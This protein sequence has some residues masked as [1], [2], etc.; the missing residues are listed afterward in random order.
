[1]AFMRG[2]PLVTKLAVLAK[3][4]VLPGAMVAALIYSPPDYASSSKSDKSQK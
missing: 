2:E 4:V 3:Y 1:M